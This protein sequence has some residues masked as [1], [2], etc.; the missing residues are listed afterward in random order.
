MQTTLKVS[1]VAALAAGLVAACLRQ[2]G[3]SSPEGALARGER[4]FTLHCAVCHGAEG[5]G[6]G[7]AAPLLFPPARDFT[8]GQFRIV[9][10]TNGVPSD[11]DLK[12][13]LSRG[14]PGSAMP[15]WGWLPEHSLD[16]LTRHV[17]ELA[18]KGVA[19]R[20]AEHARNDA[21]E[22]STAE[23][24][25]E[26]SERLRPGPEVSTTH[27]QAAMGAVYELGR[28]SYARH[29]AACHGPEGRGEQLGPELNPD[30]SPN[31][32]RD[33]TAG[34]LK[35]GGSHRALATRIVA[36]MPGSTMPSFSALP[37]EELAALTTYVSNLVPIDADRWLVHGQATLRAS[38]VRGGP[39]LS[40]GCDALD[41]RWQKADEI[42]L[43]LAP[44]AWRNDAVFEAK[45]AALHD[46]ESIALRLRWRDATRDEAS[47]EPGDARD[48][49]ALAFS[50][51]AAP[52]LFG[53]GSRA[54]PVN[55][56]HWQALRLID[57]AGVLDLVEAAPH[58]LTSPVFGEA[59]ADVKPHYLPAP[60]EPLSGGELEELSAESFAALRALDVS[61][62]AV[63]GAARWAGGEWAVVFVRQ[64]APRNSAEADLRSGRPVVVAAAIWDGS[65]GDRGGQKS[66]SIW[67][68]LV[69]E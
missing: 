34:F 40:S 51:E 35:G 54:H 25:A 68:K 60:S 49:A 12:T 37:A 66:F 7:P 46:G 52:P 43:V 31:W 26:A 23:A 14:I 48:A 6:D 5:A 2:R 24:L 22:M 59:R 4:L 9:S 1:L 65:G 29:C 27:P 17:R 36:G 3:D 32:A 39:A 10:T 67:Q 41:E 28:A 21:R 47:L 30:G 62:G 16:D 69:V 8:R 11:D 15:A 38:A 53:M 20:L 18:R 55:L 13:T 61:G 64:L 57:R 42:D 56:W 33:F 45:L 58:M 63:G 50:N 44:L 19:A